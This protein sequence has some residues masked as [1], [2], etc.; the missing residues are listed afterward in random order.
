MK[1]IRDFREKFNFRKEGKLLVGVERE[2]HLI[3]LNGNV[4]PIAPIVLKELK[5]LKRFG[6]ELSACQL[7][8]RIGPVN[9]SSVKNE[10]ENNDRII[11]N[12]L[13]QLGCSR[14]RFEVGPDDMP[15]SIYPDP[16]GRYQEITKNM[17]KH[18]LAAACRV[19]G[20]HFHIG[21]PNPGSAIEVYNG[22]I[23]HFDELCSL[24]D[25]SSGKR[26]EL[27]RLMAPDS[28]PTPYRDWDHFCRTAAEKNF[29]DDPRKCW[30]LIRISVHGT[31]EFR[32]FGTTDDLSKIAAWAN[33][34]H[35]ICE[36][37]LNDL[38]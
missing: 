34:C 9:I 17:P 15:L 18:I 23:D 6:Y 22:A 1:R 25:G 13:K 35:S 11:E 27:Y 7:E 12:I 31:I 5:D 24:G 8:D 36:K 16:T 20:T 21:M 28:R 38:P 32:M 37:I 33:K 4:A 10:L 29:L 26:L 19:I 2:C 14:S 30:T 3:G